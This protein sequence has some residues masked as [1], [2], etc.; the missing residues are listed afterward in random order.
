MAWKF[1]IVCPR[2]RFLGYGRG[3]KPCVQCYK[4]SSLARPRKFSPKAK[5]AR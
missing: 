1:L 2:C 5:G 3:E 4:K